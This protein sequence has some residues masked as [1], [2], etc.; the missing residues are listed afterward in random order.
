MVFSSITF[1]FFFLPTVLLLYLAAGKGSRNLLLLTAS[2]FFYSW[3][4][5]VYVLLM[6][7]SI[8][9]N[10]CGGL[11]V[12]GD[13]P[14]TTRRIFLILCIALNLLL[15]G[16][17]KYANFLTENLNLLFSLLN[18]T[19]IDLTPVRLPIGI[20]FFTFQ[21]LSYIIDVY[22]KKVFPQRSIINLG[23]YISLFPQLIAGPIVRYNQ[24][25]DEIKNRS[26]TMNGL[27]EGIQR[28]LFGLGKKILLANPLAAIA[29]KIFIMPENELSMG[30]AWLG[31]LSYT[32]Q[33]YFDFSGYSDMAI[34]IGRMFGFHFPENFNYPYISKSI[35]EFWQRWHISLSSWFRD[36]LYIPLGGSRRG[37]V[38]TYLNL[39]VVFVL[40]GFWHGA[41]WTFI[42]WGL[43]HGF[44]LILGRTR[45]AVITTRLWSPVRISLTFIIV[46]F[47]WVLFRSDTLPQALSYISMMLGQNQ[48]GFDPSSLS[49][50]LDA[51]A[52][53]ELFMAIVLTL[54]V[55]PYLLRL[56]QR[57]LQRWGG[58][59]SLALNTSV[60]LTQ[61]IF[62]AALSYFAVI[63]LA[64]GVYNP[65]IYFRF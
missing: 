58:T 1:L 28:F 49:P 17:F 3:G 42:V 38:R 27:A 39:L 46:L 32:L 57:L 48:N 53:F 9:I 21:A 51:K 47:G 37:P 43:Y 10:Y 44:F 62:F 40:C 25:A 52:R 5:G 64:A 33:I 55:Y 29:D 2:L 36:Y 19:N 54:P 11:L 65:F 61:L 23:L 16:Y 13:R 30:L 7:A 59:I 24:I 31:A 18:I 12:A 26:V 22:R 45:L 15:L 20:S 63:S 6:A 14:I 8:I 60:H 56:K 35:R 50:Y 34:G 41:S 4:E